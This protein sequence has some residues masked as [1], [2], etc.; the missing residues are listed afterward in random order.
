MLVLIAVILLS[1]AVITSNVVYSYQESQQ[2]IVQQEPISIEEIYQDN[3]VEI[4][5]EGNI[6]SFDAQELLNQISDAYM[7]D[8]KTNEIKSSMS[9]KYIKISGEIDTVRYSSIDGCYIVFRQDRKKSFSDGW[10]LIT[11]T[12]YNKS[13]KSK[14]LSLKAGDNV[15]IIGYCS[16]H[17]VLGPSVYDCYFLDY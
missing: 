7:D 14:A 9:E 5:N 10:I 16:K 2:K 17:F 1:G 15:T 6:P 11:C 8:D 3:K 13:E 4:L 12:F